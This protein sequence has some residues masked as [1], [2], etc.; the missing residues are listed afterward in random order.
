MRFL[1]K[2]VVLIVMAACI[3]CVRAPVTG[4]DTYLTTQDGLTAQGTW[5]AS[6][7]SIHGTVSEGTDYAY[8]YEY[9]LS[10]GGQGAISHAIFEVRQGV[11]IF[12]P[13]VKEN[14]DGASWQDWDGHSEINSHNSGGG[15]PSMPEA[16][17]GIKFN[18]LSLLDEDIKS[19]VFAFESDGAP[20]WG[21]FYAKDGEAGGAGT[22]EVW[23]AGFVSPDIDYQADH[24]PIATPEPATWVLALASGLGCG[25]IILRKKRR[26]E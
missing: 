26:Q 3:L 11:S 12:D 5:D 8:R 7:T 16:V 9:T 1:R 4:A 22:N 15:N 24:V 17:Y 2:P 19:A 13:V 20:G 23:N 21:D 10:T 25:W 6:E 14:V 18:E